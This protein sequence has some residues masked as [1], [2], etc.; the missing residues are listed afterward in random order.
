MEENLYLDLLAKRG[1][2]PTAIRILVLQ[3]MLKTRRSVSL[4]DLENILDTVDKSTIFRTITLFLSHHLI[5]SIDDGTGSFKYAVCSASCSCEVNDLHT[6]FHCER[7]NKTFCFK[8]IPTPVVNLPE[9]FT[10]NSINYVL[11]GLCPECA[12][13]VLK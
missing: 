12:A 13:K 11:K 2:Q 8:N 10:L 6:H 4:L 7:C 9:G 3:A 1:I 5:H